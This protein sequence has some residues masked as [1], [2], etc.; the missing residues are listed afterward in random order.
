MEV[1]KE[2]YFTSISS[3]TFVLITHHFCTML[4]EY[5]NNY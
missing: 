2:K 3:Y 1:F 5:I 4:K